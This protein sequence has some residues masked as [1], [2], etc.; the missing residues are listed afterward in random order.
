MKRFGLLFAL[1]LPVVGFANHFVGGHLSVSKHPDKAR[2]LVVKLLLVSDCDA[3][4]ANI[5]Y[6]NPWQNMTF[7][8][9]DSLD[10]DAQ[11][12]ASDWTLVDSGQYTSASFPYCSG[13]QTT[14]DDPLSTNIGFR[15][16]LWEGE[17]ERTPLN[18]FLIITYQECCYY[19]GLTAIQNPSQT[20]FMLQV[21]FDDHNGVVPS[22]PIPIP[23]LT[24]RACLGETMRIKAP[25]FSIPEY[26]FTEPISVT[27]GEATA[28]SGYNFSQP[29]QG[30]DLD[31]L[32][33]FPP[34]V[35]LATEYTLEP[36]SPG[37]G[38]MAFSQSQTFSG[39]FTRANTLHRTRHFCAGMPGD[40]AESAF[41]FALYK[42]GQRYDRVSNN[43]AL[44]L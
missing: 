7:H 16:A 11:T 21:T 20:D 2:T 9:P 5:I 36:Q 15:F 1:L 30:V 10:M 29:L 22:Q 40:S 44:T 24:L 43:M 14:C 38:L 25:G 37:I 3:T 8:D 31:T 35:G 23:Q 17:V 39:A 12:S 41:C 6:D 18:D 34:N 33:L 13:V 27:T 42:C 4:D 26:N 32:V 19:N 28:T